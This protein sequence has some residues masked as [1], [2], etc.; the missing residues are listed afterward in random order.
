MAANLARNDALNGISD[1]FSNREVVGFT[2]VFPRRSFEYIGSTSDALR[3]RNNYI[4]TL[5]RDPN[6]VWRVIG[7][8]MRTTNPLDPLRY[9]GVRRLVD[10]IAERVV[11]FAVNRWNRNMTDNFIDRLVTDVRSYLGLLVSSGALRRAVV[12]PDTVRNT[13]TARAA[14]L[15]YVAIQ[16]FH[17]AINE[18]I[19]FSVEVNLA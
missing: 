6:G 17:P 10:V 19:N 1:S 2:S 12:G 13:P 8:L 5:A 7:G 11:Q 3:L 16:L 9:L 4:S 15:V 14:G 18:Q